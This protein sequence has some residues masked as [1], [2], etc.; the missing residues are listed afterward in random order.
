MR[1]NS[2]PTILW[3]YTDA[4]AL[5]DIVTGQILRCGNV[6][7]LNDQTEHVYGWGMVRR[8]LERLF[9]CDAAACDVVAQEVGE[10][11]GHGQHTVI[12]HAMSF[13]AQ[14]DAVSQWQRYGSDGAGYAIGFDLNR[15]RQFCASYPAAG[16]IGKI[17]YDRRQQ[18]AAVTKPITAWHAAM[19]LLSPASGTTTSDAKTA[20]SIDINDVITGLAIDLSNLAMLLKHEDFKDEQEW[21]FITLSSRSQIPGAPAL[22]PSQFGVSRNYV[23]PYLNLS[24]A[25]SDSNLQLPIVEVKCG[26]RLNRALAV[27]SVRTLLDSFSYSGARVSFSRLSRTWR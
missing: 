16:R 15:L 3:H 14:P 13:S 20:H 4:A 5:H 1:Q 24:L 7:F 9:R 19:H 27:S 25:A 6:L 18:K 10:L 8:Q 11:M 21:R 23:K 12:P 22:L 2:E 26:P 17:I